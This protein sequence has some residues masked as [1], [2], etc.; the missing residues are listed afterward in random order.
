FAL[1]HPNFKRLKTDHIVNIESEIRWYGVEL[2]NMEVENSKKIDGYKI[3]LETLPKTISGNFD[4]QAINKQITKTKQKENKI[5]DEPN[6]NLYKTIKSFIAS[7]SNNTILPSSH[8]E[9][10]LGLDSLNYVELFIFIEQS[11]GVYIDEIIFS[12]IMTVKKL[13]RYI[14][15]HQIRSNPTSIKWKAVLDEDISE[16]LIY[17]PYMMFTYKTFLSPLFKLYFRLEIIGQENIS[18]SSCVIAPSHQSMLDGFLILSSLP[19][20]ILKKSFFLA[21]KG[22]FGKSF[23]GSVTK[24]S[25]TILIDSNYN[26]KNSMQNTALPL[27]EKQNVVIF[28][29]GARTRDRELLEFRPFFSIL[30]K[31]YKVPIVPVV[32]DGSFEALKAGMLFPRPKKI[33]ITFL[34]PIE[35]NGLSYDEITIRVK[36]AINSELKQSDISL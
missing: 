30:S 24:H 22:V 29:E 6:D 23:I 15:K 3:S 1:I 13:Y 20:S 2:Y 10:D 21:F 5:E 16:K 19:Y 17:S 32:I 35:P 7:I 27:K 28:P 14:K 34:K 26:L 31:T 4:I 11:F 9:L 8:I 36:T 18:T 12:K 25:Q 33:R